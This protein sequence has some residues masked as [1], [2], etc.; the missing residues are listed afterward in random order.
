MNLLCCLPARTVAVVVAAVLTAAAGL[1]G[2]AGLPEAPRRPAALAA[3]ADAQALAGSQAAAAWPSAWLAPLPHQG[4]PEALARW[5]QQFPDPLL[6]S[7]V[8][9]AQAAHP[10]LQ[11]ALARLQQA[12]AEA[13]Q[14]EAERLPNATGSATAQRGQALPTFQTATTLQ[15]QAALS[16]ELD[17]FGAQRAQGRAAEAQVAASQAQWHAARVSLA[18][19]VASAYLGLRQAQAQAWVA[20]RDEQAAAQLAAWA[21]QSRAAGLLSVGDA[22]LQAT[23]QAAAQAILAS[24]RAQ[25]AQALQTLALLTAQPAAALQARLDTPVPLGPDGLPQL[26]PVPPFA[27][28][29]LPAATLAQRPDLAAAHQQWLAALWAEQAVAANAWPQLSLQGLLGQARL[30]AGGGSA[31]GLVFGLGPT[32]SLPLFDGGQR[33]GQR[34]AANARSAQAAAAL[35]GRWRTAVAE[36]ENAATALQAASARQARL[37]LVR[38][39]W[40]AIARDARRLAGAGLQSGPQRVAAERNAYAA[41]GAYLAVQDEQAQAWVQLYRALG[42]GWQPSDPGPAPVAAGAPARAAAAGVAPTAIAAAA[43][44][45]APAQPL[46]ARP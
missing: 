16:W 30:S 19:D 33:A 41:L 14:T 39:Q 4:S 24:R 42:G 7:L 9:Q 21:A 20:Q 11:A 28:Q 2:C 6:A 45:T 38:Q 5:W 25:V 8:Q 35:E 44:A 37:D 13:R 1:S 15:A 27:W 17:L 29:A 31:S 18:A 40:L 10:E 46:A 22:A 23:E 36:V 26:P 43:N 32:L 3:G 12:R 34:E